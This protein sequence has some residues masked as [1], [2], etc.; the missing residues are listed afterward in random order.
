MN[1]ILKSFA[2]ILSILTGSYAEENNT[3][4][5]PKNFHSESG[6]FILDKK[7]YAWIIGSG[8]L[9]IP[10]YIR[11]KDMPSTDLN[12][13]NRNE[14]NA[15]DRPYAGVY[16]PSF[17][18]ASD[19]LVLPFCALPLAL[20]S[21]DAWKDKQ[22]IKPIFTDAV[23]FGEAMVISSS[24]DLLVRSLQV[25][26]RPF[27]YNSEVPK[28]DRLAGE[29]SGSFYS[30]HSSAAFLTAVYLSYTYPLRHP[31]FEHST[32]LWTGSL[33]TATTIAALRVSAGKHFPSDVIV[34]AIAGGFFGWLLPYLHWNSKSNNNPNNKSNTQ[35]NIPKLSMQI[36]ANGI[37]PEWTFNF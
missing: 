23:I 12:D 18:L 37:H 4:L 27:V 29:A 6:S 28:A 14:I 26:P 33:A 30:G 20:T 8:A 22:G 36:D 25:H 2:F 31:E 24:L 11:Y 3:S 13:L 9:A 5:N 34:G 19:I 7:D 16:S 1:Q 21:F 35:E 10:A 15:F 17:A 32:L